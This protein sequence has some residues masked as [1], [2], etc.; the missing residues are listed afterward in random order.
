M[1][2]H[3]GYGVFGTFYGYLGCRDAKHVVMLVIA[4]VT[5]AVNGWIDTICR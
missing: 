2:I 4:A 3:D 1:M 5:A